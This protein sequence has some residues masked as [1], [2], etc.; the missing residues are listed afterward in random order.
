M[1]RTAFFHLV[2][3]LATAFYGSLAALSAPFRP[4]RGWFDWTNRG[5]ARAI[6]WS[7]GARLEVSGAEN[8]TGER[9]QIVVANHQSVFDIFAL[10]VGLPASVRFAAKAE[11][12]RIPIFAAAC[13]AAGHVFIDRSRASRARDEIRAASERM[14]REGLTLALF[15]EGTRS[16]DGELR[17]FRKGTFRLAIETGSHLVPVALDGTARVL[18]RGGRRIR[19]GTIRVKVGPAVSLEGMTQRDR[20]RLVEETHETIRVLLD[21]LRA[22][23]GLAPSVPDA[24]TGAQEG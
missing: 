4:S 21:E 14:R 24:A 12:A 17:G 23:A 18:P 2:T 9:A 3:V 8:A 20:D 16:A 22:D 10:M 6:L 7:A 11:L 15:P 1:I 5:W 19:P 13:R